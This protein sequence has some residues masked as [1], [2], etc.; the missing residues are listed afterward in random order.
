M[1]GCNGGLRS[2]ESY[3]R[4]DSK[5]GAGT[6]GPVPDLVICVPF[7]FN[8]YLC[9]AH[10]SVRLGSALSLKVSSSRIS[11][12]AINCLGQVLLTAFFTISRTLIWRYDNFGPIFM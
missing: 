8:G 5:T 2:S 11:D 12:L 7:L 6:S 9:L 4:Y 10:I 1:L 3:Y